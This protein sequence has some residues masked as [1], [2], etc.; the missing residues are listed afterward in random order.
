[1]S[2]SFN[3]S[4]PVALSILA[5]MTGCGSQDAA[6]PVTQSKPV[7]AVRAYYGGGTVRGPKGEDYGATLT[8]AK[9]TIDP[10]ASTIVEEVTNVSGSQ[11]AKDYVVTWKIQGNTFTL[12]ENGGAF[13]GTGELHG[14]PW[15]WDGWTFT[16]TLDK[17]MGTVNADEWITGEGLDSEKTFLL[18]NNSVG[19]RISERVASIPV[20]EY[21]WRRSD[22]KKP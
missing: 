8:A 17:G 20:D 18:P 13:T 15:N 2:L 19:A 16:T 5:L 12:E 1:M 14:D 11:P 6:A 3:G 22:L 9:R 21:E 4:F 7:K 10:E